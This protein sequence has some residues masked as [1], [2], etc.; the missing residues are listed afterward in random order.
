MGFWVG[1]TTPP[2]PDDV[3]NL[4][5]QCQHFTRA[6]QKHRSTFSNR[7]YRVFQGIQS[8]PQTPNK[9]GDHSPCNLLVLISGTMNPASRVLQALRDFPGGSMV[10]NPPSSAG[11]T[12]SIPGWGTKIPHATGQ[13][14]LHDT[15]IELACSGACTLQLE[16]SSTREKPACRKE[17]FHMATHP[18]K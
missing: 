15:A 1:R 7:G 13:L 17:R 10:K 4:V 16:R 5:W 12:G 18:K 2:T 11:H 14:S 6:R 9:V 3:H 8:K